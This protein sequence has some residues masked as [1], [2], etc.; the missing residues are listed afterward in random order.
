MKVKTNMSLTP[1][2]KQKIQHRKRQAMHHRR[3]RDYLKPYYPYL[4]MLMIVG[5]GIFVNSLLSPSSQVL[6][7][8]VNFMSSSLLQSTNADRQANSDGSLMINPE[9]TDAAETK[10]SDMVARNYWAHISP[11]NQ[12]PADL[13]TAVGYQYQSAGENLA[14]GFNSASAVVAAWMNSPDHRANM[15]NPNFSD[16]GFG[17]AQ[18]SN[19]LGHG[20]AVIVVAEYAQPAGAVLASSTRVVS[21]PASQPV[22]R[23]QEITGGSDEW[24]MLG[25]AALAGAAMASLIIRHGFRLRRWLTDGEMFIVHHPMLDIAFVLI[26]TVG[27]ILMRTVGHIG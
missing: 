14:Y 5:L 21:T 23:V 27:I 13:V 11:S 3:S 24:L 10:A 20:P 18:S 25:I 17:V 26:C 16:V 6:G 22:A 19:Y 12:T 8:Q 2:P 15:L 9:L 4:P 7:S 1:R